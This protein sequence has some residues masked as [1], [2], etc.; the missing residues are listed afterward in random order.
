MWEV[1]GIDVLIPLF[2]VIVVLTAALAGIAIW[3]PRALRLKLTALGA[4]ALLL[5][6]SYLSPTELLGR[7]TPIDLE[8]S[9][10]VFTDANVLATP[11]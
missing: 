5:P 3:A 8:W 10:P 6:A 1:H 9:P 7:P 2:A 11:P 4:V